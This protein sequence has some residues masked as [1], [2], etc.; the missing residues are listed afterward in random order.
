MVSEDWVVRCKNRRLQ[1]ERQ[2]P[3]WASAK[4]R[5]LVRENGRDCHSLSWA[6][7]RFRQLPMASTALSEGRGTAPSFALPSPKPVRSLPAPKHHPWRQGYG[8]MRTP[9]FSPVW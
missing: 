8:N 4:S 3:H 9:V 6:S 7:L 1:L 2:S 5:V